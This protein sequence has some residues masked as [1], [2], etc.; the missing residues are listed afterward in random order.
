MSKDCQILVFLVDLIKMVISFA[1]NLDLLNASLLDR[2]V[3]QMDSRNS[4][5]GL[6]SLLNLISCLLFDEI[7]TQA[8][9]LECAIRALDHLNEFLS[10]VL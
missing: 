7:V 2:V 3:V 10:D 9:H 8:Q 1:E 4:P 5:I 6:Q